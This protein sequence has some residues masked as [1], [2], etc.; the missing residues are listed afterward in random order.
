MH[1]REE[2]DIE[3]K[4]GELARHLGLEL[5]QHPLL[6]QPQMAGW[7]AGEQK[8]VLTHESGSDRFRI[9]LKY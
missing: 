3:R 2:L 1:Y 5:K 9:L 6:P 7:K 8:S 4:N